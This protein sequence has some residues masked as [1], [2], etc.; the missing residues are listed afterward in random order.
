MS[1]EAILGADKGTI[2]APAGCG[3]T[4]L[5]CKALEYCQAKP[6]LVLTHTTAGVYALKKRLSFLGIPNKNFEVA[7]I[8]GWAKKIADFFPVSC[9]ITENINNKKKYYP[10]LRDNVYKYIN[11]G[12]IFDIISA[13][14]SR[15][16]VDEYQ[17]CN[18]SQH[19][20][21]CSLSNVLPTIVFGDPMQCIFNFNGD[22]ANWSKDVIV[23]FPQIVVLNKP[24]RWINAKNEEL[25]EWVLSCRENLINGS[26]INLKESP[27]SVQYY[28]FNS[29]DSYKYRENLELQIKVQ[30]NLIKTFKNESLLVIGSSTQPK[31]RFQYAS[32]SY[33]IQVV[34]T[35]DLDDIKTMI[36]KL[37][38]LS[39]NFSIAMQTINTLSET[40]CGVEKSKL[41]KRI[42]SLTKGTNRTEA[43]AI[44]QAVMSV[45]NNGSRESIRDLI[46]TVEKDQKTRVYR[47]EALSIFKKSIDESIIKPNTTISRACEAVIE[48]RKHLGDNR[49]PPRAIGSTLL[50]KGLECDHSLILNTTEMLNNGNYKSGL[51]NLYVALSRASKSIS[52]FS[53]SEI[54]AS[55]S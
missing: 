16:L 44:E 39:D 4:H 53:D 45:I 21:I 18:L 36:S 43:N 54:L 38:N 17:D 15:L 41:D 8:D 40:M 28:K 11:T 50:L 2:V 52:I 22:I 9:N 42:P 48:Q 3:K 30:N 7:T 5:L 33:G 35:V 13:S 31:K 10:M 49:I 24:W 1:V 51:N 32:S 23:K 6:Y 29:A 55:T 47:S 12:N 27:K 19:N 37:D 46:I 34:E 26:G 14:Y 25:G 20:L